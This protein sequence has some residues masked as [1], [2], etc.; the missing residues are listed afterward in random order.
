LFILHV[1]YAFV[2]LGFAWIA[3][4]G[5]G[6]VGDVAALH[7]MTVGAVSTMMLAVMTRATR[8]HTGRRL[9]A[10]PLTQISY[11]AVL[12]AAVV[13]PAVDFA[14]EAATLLYAIAGLAHVAAF[15]LFLVEYAPMLATAR[16]G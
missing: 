10:S 13:R 1:A 6:L 7:V 4:A 3:A 15:A 14:P 5:L 16:R 12:V 8:G 11:A 2:P 9:T